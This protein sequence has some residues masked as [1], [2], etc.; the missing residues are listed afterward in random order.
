MDDIENDAHPYFREEYICRINRAIDYIETHLSEKLS[1]ETIAKAAFFSPF[2][3]HRIFHGLV[4]ETLNRFIK[5][6]RVEKAARMLADNPKQ[7]VSDIALDCGFSTTSTLSRAFKETF[8]MSPTAWRKASSATQSKICQTFRKTHQP[9]GSAR[10]NYVIHTSY[11]DRASHHQ[12]WRIEMPK[13]NEI[14]VTVKDMPEMTVAYVRHIGAYKSNEALFQGLFEKLMTWAGPRGLLR[15]PETIC[16]SVYHDDPNITDEQKLRTSVCISVP[17]NTEVDG[18]VGKMT[19]PGGKYAVGHFE[20]QSSEYEA[21]WNAL[22][23][24]WLPES[25]YQPDDR[26]SYEIYLNNPNTHPEGKHIVEIC[27]P[28]RP[29]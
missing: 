13:Q 28:V 11:F 27:V 20:I 18:E 19:I 3:F 23:S 9:I 21:S 4:G 15:F 22:W 6:L 14:Q 12:T 24:A 16:L 10:K 5:R 2:H 1:L 7:T 17:P 26:L 8:S 29:L 25:G